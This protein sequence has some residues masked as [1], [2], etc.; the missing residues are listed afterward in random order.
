MSPGSRS[1]MRLGITGLVRVGQVFF[2]GVGLMSGL[3]GK[4]TFGVAPYLNAV[5][6]QG[7]RK[8]LDFRPSGIL[9]RSHTGVRDSHCGGQLLTL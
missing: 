8:I 6:T 1:L 4:W 5:H 2:E 7:V 3:G 9:L